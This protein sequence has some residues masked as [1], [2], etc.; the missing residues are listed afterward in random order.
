MSTKPFLSIDGQI[1]LLKSRELKIGS[2][3]YDQACEFFLDNNYYRISGYSL[4]LRNNDVFSEKASL[5]ALM[6]IYNADRRMRHV[7]LS[8]IEVIEIRIKSMLAYFHCEKYGPI[9]YL[10]INNFSCLKDGKIDL[11]IV[12]NY[13]YITRKGDNQ[14]KAMSESELFIKHHK[15]NKNNILPFWVYIEVLTISDASKL[16]TMLDKELQKKIASQLGFNY[17]KGPDIVGN[18]LHCVTILRNISA[19]AGRLYNRLFITKPRLSTKE[20]EQLRTENET[21]VNNKLFSYILVLKSLTHTNDF[22]LVI[23]H[24]SEIYQ[25]NPLVDFKYYGF[26]DNWKDVLEQTANSK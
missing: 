11:K 25:Q 19:H 23:D 3:E 6:Q 4:T 2:K 1:E 8:I 9:G 15:E 20:K 17:S 24:I 13:L 16:Y 18:L 22:K 26:P 10:D 12:N 21:V 14:K 5:D 7:M